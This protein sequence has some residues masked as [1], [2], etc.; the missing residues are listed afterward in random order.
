MIRFYYLATVIFLLLDILVDINV[1]VAFLEGF[2]AL[3]ATYYAVIFTCMALIL[4]RPSW[5]DVIGA[6]ESLTSLVALILSMG[7]R[8]MVPG[9]AMV[10]SGAGFVTV[11]EI[12]NFLIVGFIG[13]YSW[14]HGM[15]AFFDK[16]RTS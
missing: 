1:R 6:V 8:V 4:W 3:R 5:A 10:N 16:T 13:Y 2:P 7:V 9:S 12:F 15:Q 14:Q 11:P